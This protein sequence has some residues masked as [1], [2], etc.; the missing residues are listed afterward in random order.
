MN[1]V[2][3]ALLVSG[4]A[5]GPVVARADL[6][7][8]ARRAMNVNVGRFDSTGV[9]VRGGVGIQTGQTPNS[10]T[11][12]R[13]NTSVGGP[14]GSFDFGASIRQAFDELPEMFEGLIGAV[15]SS[16]P[17]AI[18][19]Y[20]SPTLCDLAKHWQALSNLAIQARYGHCQQIQTAMAYGAMRLR[21][22]QTSQCLEDEA[23]SGA[24]LSEAMRTCNG[25]VSSVRSPSG[26][27]R[28]SYELVGGVLEASGASQETQTLANELLGTITISASGGRIGANHDRRAGAML[29]RFE[30][31]QSEAGQ[32]LNV[33]LEELR[34]TGEVSEATLREIS[35]PGQ[36]VPRAAL[37]ALLALRGD[38]VRYDAMAGKLTTGLA[39]TRLTWECAQLQEELAVA[40]A[41]NGQLKDEERR[42]LEARIETV[43]RE[44]QAV[45]QKAEVI[46]RHLQPAMEEL[47]SQYQAVQQV[48]TRA[49][50]KAASRA[51]QAMP[52]QR[53]APIGYGQ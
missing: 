20:A 16:L 40:V 43:G 50:L 48:A 18:L 31:H 10:L 35:V 12:L 19:C 26:D 53:Q 47:L 15:I 25:E 41:G 1:R 21:G 2:V 27:N 36:P 4:I 39:I 5:W 14:C 29:R 45:T 32:A 7:D 37:E 3:L 8:Q 44:L 42:I 33:A 24:S 6:F 52:F 34:Q 30:G 17:M 38:R 46:Q 11:L 13:V 22:G 28:A 49:G 23:N 51:P 9:S